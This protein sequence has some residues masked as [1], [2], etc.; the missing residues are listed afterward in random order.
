L[1]PTR[2]RIGV[3]PD[4]TVRFASV[5]RSCGKE[6]V[7][8]QAVEL[9]QQIRF[10]PVTDAKSSSLDWGVVKMLWATELPPVAT[11]NGAKQ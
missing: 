3:A 10:E 2:V 7:D 11:G 1:K 5:E 9:A 4:G 6:T 8:A